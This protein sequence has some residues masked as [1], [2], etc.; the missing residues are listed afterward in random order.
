MPADRPEDSLLHMPDLGSPSRGGKAEGVP[1]DP[2]G[3]E[4]EDG[5]DRSADEGGKTNAELIWIG[6]LDY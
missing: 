1:D 4:D 5:A 3:Q 2:A 6:F